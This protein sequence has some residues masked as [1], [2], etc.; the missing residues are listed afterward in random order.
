MM[1]QSERKIKGRIVV[2]GILFS[3]PIAGVAWQHLHYLLGLRRLGYDV[4]YI[5]LDDFYPFDPEGDG[6]YP[7]MERV[8]GWSANVLEKFGF[9]GKW[10]YQMLWEERTWGISSDEAKKTL[11]E[12]DAFIN[13]CGAQTLTDD[14]L[15]CP[16]RLFLETDPVEMQIELGKGIEAAYAM[17]RQ[18]TALYTFG[19]NLGTEA[20]PLSNGGFTWHPT[21][22]A[23]VLDEWRTETGPPPNAPYT[24]V[25]NWDVKD[26]EV[27]LDGKIYHWQKGMEFVKVRNLPRR[28]NAPLELAMRFGNP[29]DNAMMREHGWRTRAALGVSRDLDVYRNYIQQSRGEFTVAKEQNIVFQTGWFSDRAAAYL[30]A[31]RPVINQDTGFARNLPTGEGLF[32]FRDEDGAAAA[33]AT[34]ESDYPRHCEA[35]REIARDYFSSDVLLPRMLA[36]AGME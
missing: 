8:V 32:S 18:H 20:C 23:V 36:Q 7:D 30:A 13:L 26:K 21:R 12:A 15:A 17:L 14:H 5:E 16:R 2:G 29:A 1:G 35:A 28:V 9:A 34:I 10:H 24:T 11:R 27:E 4:T 22:Q 19:E 33:I 25:G 6:I 31:G 3:Y